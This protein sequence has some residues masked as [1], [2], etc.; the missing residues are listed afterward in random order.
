[1]TAQRVQSWV[2]GS[3][4]FCPTVLDSGFGKFKQ[5]PK[6]CVLGKLKQML[7]TLSL[8]KTKPLPNG[9]NRGYWDF[10]VNAKLIQS[11]VSKTS[12]NWPMV[13]NSVFCKFKQL[14]TF[15]SLGK[16]KPLPNPCGLE[17]FKQM[18]KNFS[19][20][21]LKQLQIISVQK[22]AQY[23]QSCEDQTIAEWFS[24]RVFRNS[25]NYPT[26]SVSGSSINI[27]KFFNSG[28]WKLKQ[29]SNSF[30]RSFGKFKL[31]A[32]GFGLWSCEVQPTSQRV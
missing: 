20:G 19:L 10:Q 21:K 31:L 25:N 5:L 16:F 32:N 2:S 13:L 6:T 4:K 15:F 28:L 12:K 7:K 9:F 27:P 18:P 11:W 1:M 14:P 29:L 17:K 23:L 22:T 26:L 30:N 3:W 8:G 24:N